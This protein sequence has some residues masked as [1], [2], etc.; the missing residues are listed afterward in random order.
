[1]TV[2]VAALAVASAAV[3]FS[4]RVG[5]R[6]RIAA[7]RAEARVYAREFLAQYRD[8]IISFRGTN[9]EV[10]VSGYSEAISYHADQRRKW[11]RA[12]WTPWLSVAADPPAPEWRESRGESR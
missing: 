6:R 1:M 2:V 12:A 8:G 4:I 5:E 11:E 7:R 3:S 9:P 10:V